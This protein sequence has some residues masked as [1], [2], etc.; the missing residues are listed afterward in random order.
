MKATESEILFRLRSLD[1]GMQSKEI[2]ENFYSSL[3][4]FTNLTQLKVSSPKP[5]DVRLPIGCNLHH[6]RDLKLRSTLLADEDGRL[7]F[8]SLTDLTK[9][10]VFVDIDIDH[11]PT[12]I[13]EVRKSFLTLSMSPSLDHSPLCIFLVQSLTLSTLRWNIG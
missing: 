3:T 8:P 9:L 6:I 1:I 12:E 5:R 10:E 4:A 7:R 11:F 2:L 13:L